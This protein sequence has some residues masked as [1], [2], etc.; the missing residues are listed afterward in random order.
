MWE[1]NQPH[2]GGEEDEG[3]KVG[4]GC[5]GEEGVAGVHLLEVDEP[6]RDVIGLER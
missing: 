2:V 4:G 5:V 6:A 1:G 3:E